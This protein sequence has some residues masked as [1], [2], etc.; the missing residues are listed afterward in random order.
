VFPFNMEMLST[1]ELFDYLKNEKKFKVTRERDVA[2]AL[3]L[4]G[5]RCKK[6][7][8]ITKVADRATVW[9]INN[10]DELMKLSTSELGRK[11]VPFFY[12][13]KK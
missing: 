5:G 6:Q 13:S 1:V 8:P 4:I 2:T 9:I 12:D 11:Y 3:E 10:H 7:I